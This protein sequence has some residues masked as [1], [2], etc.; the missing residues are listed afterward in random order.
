MAKKELAKVETTAELLASRTKLIRTTIE[1]DK[2]KETL[3]PFYKKG[4][5][6]GCAGCPQTEDELGDCRAHFLEHIVDHPDAVVWTPEFDLP[7]IR[8]REYRSNT[9]ELVGIGLVCARCYVA[10]KCPLKRDG[11][12]C[13]I[14]WGDNRPTQIDDFFDFLVKIQF[15]R[16]KRASAFERMDGGVPDANLSSEMDRLQGMLLNK[17]NLGRSSFEMS[18]KGSMPSSGDG[19]ILSKLFGGGKEAEA[20]PEA[21]KRELPKIPAKDV[22]Y[23]ILPKEE[24]E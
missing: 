22:E 18:I 20:L 12:E 8:K 23:E 3:C 9:D 11:F 17:G 5:Y 4:E 7:V 24:E 19:G 6:S 16:V 14:D 15:E 21:E 13:G 2:L 1:E 10:D